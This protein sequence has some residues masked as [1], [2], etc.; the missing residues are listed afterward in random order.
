M[1]SNSR[2]G[3]YFRLKQRNVLQLSR[4]WNSKGTQSSRNKEP[5]LVLFHLSI[6]I[7]CIRH[8]HNELGKA[9]GLS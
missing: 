6:I 2:V 4:D 1:A 9:L 3:N 7:I 8:W 5:N